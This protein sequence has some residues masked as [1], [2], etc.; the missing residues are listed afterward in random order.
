M[1]LG[2][3][4]AW[5]QVKSK[6]KTLS[7]SKF[8][9]DLGA[10]LTKLETDFNQ[11]DDLKKQI[12]ALKS[13]LLPFIK[14]V[15]QAR[16]DTKDQ[17]EAARKQ[18]GDKASDDYSKFLSDYGDGSDWDGVQK[19]CAAYTDSIKKTVSS[20]DDLVKQLTKSRDT[21]SKDEVTG[22]SQYITKRKQVEDKYKKAA[23]ERD[24]LL[25]QIPQVIG[26]YIKVAKQMKDNDLAD[27]INSIT[28]KLPSKA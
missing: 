28:K 11:A 19:A 1:N 5:K 22:I 4:A 2:L 27:D 10:L 23:E 8:K 25:D 12:D 26:T 15:S 13:G 24:R 9:P 3:V 6:H 14:D 7:D 20:I 17:L 21:S 16:K 18:L